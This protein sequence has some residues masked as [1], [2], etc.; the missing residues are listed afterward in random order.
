[1]RKFAKR[2]LRNESGA[3][4]ILLGIAATPLIGAT[5]IAVD[6]GRLYLEERDLQG[7]ADAAA[8][9]S[10]SGE[11]IADGG[12]GRAEALLARSGV[13]NIAIERFETGKFT[14]DTATPIDERFEK[15]SEEINAAE[16][17]LTREVPLLMGGFLGINEAAVRARARAAR[18]NMVAFELGSDLLGFDKNLPGR[19]LEALAETNLGLNKVQVEAILGAQL[20]LV[21][22]I[23]ALQ[24]RVGEDGQTLDELF[25]DEASL[26]DV[27]AAM[28]DAAGDA[29]T[30]DALYQIASR[31]SWDEIRL[32]QLIDI[33]PLG[34]QMSAGRDA[35]GV[36]VYMMLRAALQAGQGNDYEVELSSSIEGFGSID[37]R[38]AGGEHSS[39]TPFLAV[40]ALKNV[41]LR[42]TETRVSVTMKTTANGIGNVQLPVLIDLAPAEA[43]VARVVCDP[44]DP[45]NGVTLRVR[46][47][48]GSVK[49]GEV[50]PY[51]FDD[52]TTAPNV[53]PASLVDTPVLDIK[54]YS[55][56]DVGGREDR[57]VRLSLDEID[58]QIR[59]R[60]ETRDAVE[61][62]IGSLLS[63]LDVEVT[64]AGLNVGRSSTT[65]EDQLLRG[66]LKLAPSVDGVLNEVTDIVGV[67]LGVADVGVTR[68]SCGRPTIVG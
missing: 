32:S 64:T 19:Y 44:F 35:I 63:D 40:D 46:P 67:K 16:I 33:G 65:M 53:S 29:E 62:L 25:E 21:Q 2:L 49:I 26:A 6:F 34:R 43:Q 8:S 13:E 28:G 4:A 36:S 57:F 45:D 5:V 9:A 15:G 47:S 41:I 50:D 14:A 12:Y 39:E 56:L 7:L 60:V 3:S 20:D 61:A 22:F 48:I 42:T 52:F 59:K 30:R 54:A 1:M 58:S 23:E 31:V 10:V 27:I 66:L 18:T 38:I 24:R 17:E 37:V 11:D 68:L 51:D 55:S